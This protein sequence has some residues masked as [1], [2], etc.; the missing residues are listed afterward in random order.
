MYRFLIGETVMKK[1]VLSSLATVL[2]YASTSYASD[3]VAN[4]IA[5]SADAW[6]YS[7]TLNDKPT[8]SAI[9]TPLEHN[10][11]IKDSIASNVTI[12]SIY[13]YRASDIQAFQSLPL[14]REIPF[15]L[16]LYQTG[17]TKVETEQTELKKLMGFSG[18]IGINLRDYIQPNF[19]LINYMNEGKGVGYDPDNLARQSLVVFKTEYAT[20]E[21]TVKFPALKK[22]N[23]NFKDFFIGYR[24]TDYTVP[25]SIYVMRNKD[26]LSSSSRAKSVDPAFNWQA[27]YFL[28]GFDRW[29][30]SSYKKLLET[31]SDNFNKILGNR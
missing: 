4:Y 12:E 20:T 8:I 24:M 28:I 14:I 7:W 16:N 2:F 13:G 23:K 21:L 6:S 5:I 31:G 17:I 15:S 3:T 29:F 19:K 27:N 11:Q 25:Q 10:Y 1:I 9:K 30:Q 26:T 18:Y 22:L